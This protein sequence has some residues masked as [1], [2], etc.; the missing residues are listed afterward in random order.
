[1]TL[2]IEARQLSLL[3]AD[4]QWGSA[5]TRVLD[6][7]DLGVPE[8]AVV[9]LVGRNGAGKSTLMR[10]LLGLQTPDEG[11]ARLLGDPAWR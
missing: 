10:C 5:R 1:M 3:V 7:V 6:H 2:A 8:G 9:G 11:E 4:S